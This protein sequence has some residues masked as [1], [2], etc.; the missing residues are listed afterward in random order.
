MTELHRPTVYSSTAT[1]PDPVYCATV[2]NNYAD[3]A[4]NRD[5]RRYSNANLKPERSRQFSLGAVLAAGRNVSA[6]LDYW[7]IKRTDL[8]SEIGDDIILGTWPNM[9]TWC[10]ATKTA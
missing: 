7:D 5:T 10:T 2:E 4:D 9:A 6:S 1:L 3:C 8:I